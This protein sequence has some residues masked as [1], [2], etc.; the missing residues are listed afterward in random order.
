MSTGPT[1]NQGYT[2]TTIQPKALPDSDLG[3]GELRTFAGLTAVCNMGEEEIM[4][5]LKDP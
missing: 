4:V 2:P 1:S 5:L 3:D